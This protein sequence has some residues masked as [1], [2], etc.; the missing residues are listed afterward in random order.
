MGPGGPVPN[1][2][3]ATLSLSQQRDCNWGNLALPQLR[4]YC[5]STVHVLNP[6]L[7]LLVFWEFLVFSPCEE[8]LGFFLCF[9]LLFQGFQGFGTDKNPC[10]FDGFPC[11]FL[12]KQGKEG[13]GRYP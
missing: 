6:V 5:S 12:K 4:E 7:P 9:S 11:L 1:K 2:P 10:F 13:Q 3:L 8:F